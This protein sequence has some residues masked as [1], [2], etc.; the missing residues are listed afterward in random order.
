MVGC[1]FISVPQLH[2]RWDASQPAWAA[3]DFWASRFPN[4]SL[5]PSSFRLRER[6]DRP[7]GLLQTGVL[8]GVARA[9]KLDCP[10]CDT[11]TADTQP[12]RNCWSKGLRRR[13]RRNLGLVGKH[14]G[15]RGEALRPH[16]A[17]SATAGLAVKTP[18]IQTGVH[19]IMHQVAS[20]LESG[21]VNRL[22]LKG[23]PVAQPG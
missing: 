10:V 4:R 5:I 1:C 14:G 19:Q 16:P 18:E 9:A 23:R 21:S 22:I 7:Q 8:R 11:T 15:P 20:V 17:R 3:F 2:F 12:R 13:R 6:A